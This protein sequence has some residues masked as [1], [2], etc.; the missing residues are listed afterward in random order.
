MKNHGMKGGGSVVR[1]GRD[2]RI[3]TG[4]TSS[5]DV[6]RVGLTGRR[7]RQ[8]CVSSTALERPGWQNASGAGV[9]GGGINITCSRPVHPPVVSRN[10]VGSA[11]QQMVAARS[12][13]VGGRG[14]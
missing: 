6:Y 10:V 14:W 13:R 5:I 2:I 1:F 9:P 11:A 7:Y 3:A 12:R 8:V 4:I